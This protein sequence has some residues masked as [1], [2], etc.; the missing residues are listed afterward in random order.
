MD[1]AERRAKDIKATHKEVCDFYGFDKSDEMRHKSV[2]FFEM[3]SDFLRDVVN[4]LPKETQK[5]NKMKW[6]TKQDQ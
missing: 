2:E 6:R 4:A 5:K 1:K 3:W